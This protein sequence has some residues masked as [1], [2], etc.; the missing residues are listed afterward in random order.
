MMKL[1]VFD[2]P[3]FNRRLFF[4]R[5]DPTPPPDGARDCLVDVGDGERVHGR[6]HDAPHARACL[7]FFH[8]N[9]DTVNDYDV[10]AEAFIRIGLLPV[11][12]GYRGYGQSTGTPTLRAACRDAHA[13]W[14][15]LR[16]GLL[17]ERPLPLI[18]MGRSLGSSPAIELAARAGGSASLIIESGWADPHGVIARRGYPPIELSAEELETFSNEYKMRRVNA[19]LLVMHGDL[20]V[21]IA[22]HEAEMNHA[23]AASP[24]KR[25]VILRGCGHNNIGMHPDYFGI[26]A[27][28][29]DECIPA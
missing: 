14:S 18:L 24:H 23:A 15:H 8:G 3:E 1:S 5:H 6:I 26:L 10:V 9:G 19:P 22:P 16:A 12:F 28:F 13:I 17:T 7:L 29:V 21:L 2:E 11:F 25:L 27:G 4:P 20:D